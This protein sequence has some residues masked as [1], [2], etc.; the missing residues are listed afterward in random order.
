MKTQMQENK[1]APS[2]F[3]AF[4]CKGVRRAAECKRNMAF[5]MAL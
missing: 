3:I 1:K 5:I 4:H 2:E